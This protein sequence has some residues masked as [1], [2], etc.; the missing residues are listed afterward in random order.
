M[1]V[2]EGEA[3]IMKDELSVGRDKISKG[4]KLKVDVY[5]NRKRG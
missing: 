1:C 2:R 5:E 4:S 3:I